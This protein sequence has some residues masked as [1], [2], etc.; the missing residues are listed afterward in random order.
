MF[1]RS[2]DYIAAQSTECSGPISNFLCARIRRECTC[3]SPED[4]ICQHWPRSNFYLT[5][6]GRCSFRAIAY[7]NSRCAV[8]GFANADIRNVGFAVWEGPQCRDPAP[9]IKYRDTEVPPTL[10]QGQDFS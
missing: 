1:W 8:S 7:R 9:S 6:T 3:P 4:L 5:A 10:G 2:A